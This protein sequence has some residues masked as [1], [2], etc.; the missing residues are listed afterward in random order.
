[1]AKNWNLP[2]LSEE[3]IC[4]SP[5]RCRDGAKPQD[6]AGNGAGAGGLVFGELTGARN[7]LGAAGNRPVLRLSTPVHDCRHQRFDLCRRDVQAR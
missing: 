3:H 6:E 5:C 2:H 4:V 1:M 7:A